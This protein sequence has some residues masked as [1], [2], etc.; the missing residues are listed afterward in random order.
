LNNSYS[1]FKLN[2]GIKTGLS[3]AHVVYEGN[4]SSSSGSRAGV[5]MGLYIESTFNKDVSLSCEFHYIQKGEGDPGWKTLTECLSIPVL[6]KLKT[7]AGKFTPYLLSGPRFDFMLS[8]ENSSGATTELNNINFG[9]TL[10]LGSEINLWKSNSLV[11]EIRYDHDLT[12][13]RYVVPYNEYYY[14]NTY[15]RSF[16]F[17]I[18]VKF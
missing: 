4:R 7:Q 1:Q 15:N 10:G 6:L 13:S 3:L 9:V 8:Y 17:L 16:D 14:S 12:F 11:A 5:D 2:F 18:G